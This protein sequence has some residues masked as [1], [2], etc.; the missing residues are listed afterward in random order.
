MNPNIKSSQLFY[1]FISIENDADFQKKKKEYEKMK[2]PVNINDFQ[3]PFGKVNIQINKKK[4]TYFENIKDNISFNENLLTKLNENFKI[5][6]TQID[7]ITLKID[8]IAQ[9]WDDLCQNSIKYFEGDD[10]IKTY[11]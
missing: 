6:K 10:I 9:N 8:E 5:L 3:S 2:P 1:D 7:N 4:T 11:E